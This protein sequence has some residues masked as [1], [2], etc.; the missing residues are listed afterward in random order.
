M[1]NPI[2]YSKFNSN[3]FIF[4][5]K[6]NPNSTFG[7]PTS[8]LPPP[9]NLLTFNCPGKFLYWESD[10]KDLIFFTYHLYIINGNIH[11]LIRLSSLD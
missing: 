3:I 1:D 4:K 8:A 2:V 10:D 9:T 11:H 5:A 7:R 6:P